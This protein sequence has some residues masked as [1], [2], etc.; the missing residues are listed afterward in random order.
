MTV[1]QTATGEFDQPYELS[2]SAPRQFE[3]DG[4]IHLTDV[5]PAGC[6]D[7]IEP[8]ITSNVIE[9]NTNTRPLAER[10]TYSK[11]FLQIENLWQHSPAVKQLAFSRRLAQI[12]ADLMGVRSVRIFHDQA[13]YKEPN[14][15]ITPWHADQYYWPMTSDRCCTI[16]LPLQDTPVEMGPLSFARGSHR[17]PI[18]RDLPIGDDSEQK[19]QQ[20]LAEQQCEIVSEPYRRGEASY[21]L[22]WTF[23]RA[24]A[25]ISTTPRRVM[26]VIY[27]DADIRLNEDVEDTHPGLIDRW[28][29]GC[30]PGG[31]A[32]STQTPVL[33]P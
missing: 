25:N 21:H 18:G 26:T 32:D 15:G 17:L 20:L 4:F 9:L 12:A 6:I 30:P 7:A 8:E 28:F 14:G 2:S 24:S 5:L 11:A 19:L 13:L 3:E 23:H 29:P 1:T 27:L 31:V 22:G 16:W 33:Y 10:D